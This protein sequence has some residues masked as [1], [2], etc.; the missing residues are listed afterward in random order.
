TVSCPLYPP[1]FP[2]TSLFRSPLAGGGRGGDR[3]GRERAAA[4]RTPLPVRG[5]LPRAGAGQAVPRLDRG[6][7]GG[8][9][10]R[11]PGHAVFVGR[12]RGERPRRDGGT[13]DGS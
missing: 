6:A 10:P 7:G 12:C 4:G 8:R 11:R 9:A 13:L 1:F 5:V 3:L 2:Y